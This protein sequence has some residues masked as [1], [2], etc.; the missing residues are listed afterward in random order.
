MS[1]SIS[2]LETSGALEE[3]VNSKR[4]LEKE[5]LRVDNAG[6]ISTLPHN[7]ELGSALTNPYITTDFSESLLELITP[8]FHDPQECLDFMSDIH[9][10]VY[11]HINEE[12]MWP[13][14][15]PPPIEDE[16][17][18]PIGN[19][20]SSNT[21]ML[22]TIY[23]RGLSHRYGS[24]MQAISGI[25]YNFSFSNEFFK[26]IHKTYKPNSSVLELKNNLYLGMAR[27][28]RRY[29]WLYFVLFGAS[30][31]TSESFVGK[32]NAHFTKF[33]VDGLYKIDATSL[34][35]GDL[36]YIS[37]A[38]DQLSISMNSL[39]EYC[40]DLNLALKNKYKPYTDVGEFNEGQRIQLNDS[41]IQIEN[42]YYSTI[43]PKRVCP[44]GER[45]VNILKDKGIEYLELRCVDLDPFN[46]IGIDRN[47]IDF[48][49]MMLLYCLSKESPPINKDENMMILKNHREIIDRGRNAD[50]KIEK[51]GIKIST[52]DYA[53]QILE[54][55]SEM[56]SSV[57]KYLFGSSYNFWSES[58]N[59]Q[60]DKIQ[61]YKKLPSSI[62]I[63]S[64]L[65]GSKSYLDFNLDLASKNKRYFEEYVSKNELKFKDSAKISLE[66]QVE[67]ENNEEEPFEEYLRSFLRKTS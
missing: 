16:N 30:P 8:T 22:K 53:S 58:L 46:P 60:I 44:S 38:Q 5:S 23:R 37:A 52:F 40:K 4:G 49:D 51:K 62:V 59:K 65:E 55:L 14:S 33:S 64:I 43:R 56:N 24:I 27:N 1:L 17:K 50:L 45:P 11:K 28:F 32:H 19:Y 20:G 3:L 66:K 10:F 7:K 26:R 9:S 67:I 13:S 6:N 47:Q 25:H 29:S 21:G 36:G 2:D 39:D 31:S 12:M 54:E 57:G 18:I 41:I 48:L 42:E 34:R 63:N 35:M 15:M 61:D